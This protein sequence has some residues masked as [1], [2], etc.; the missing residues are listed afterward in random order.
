MLAPV[1]LIVAIVRKVEAR[2]GAAKGRKSSGSSTDQFKVP[3]L[4]HELEEPCESGSYGVCPHV[5][6]CSRSA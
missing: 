3:M 1:G 6:Y 4:E 5:A 2:T